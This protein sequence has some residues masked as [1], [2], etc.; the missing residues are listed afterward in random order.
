[1]DD[2]EEINNAIIEKFTSH[3]I[4][5][6]DALSDSVKKN[7]EQDEHYNNI[8]IAILKKN[9]GSIE[10]EKEFVEGFDG[11]EVIVRYEHFADKGLFK[12]WLENKNEQ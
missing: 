11:L 1:M 12:I 3:N 9:G 2:K 6:L 8:I 4:A 10:I 7:K 5:L